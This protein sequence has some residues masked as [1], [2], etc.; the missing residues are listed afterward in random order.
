MRI[1]KTQGSATLTRFVHDPAGQLAQE[2]AP[3]SS[4]TSYYLRLHGN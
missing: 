1:A 3:G 2:I 4:T